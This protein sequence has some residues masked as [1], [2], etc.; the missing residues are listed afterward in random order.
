MSFKAEDIDIDSFLNL[1]S[2]FHSPSLANINKGKG[3]VTPRFQQPPIEKVNTYAPL[4]T[5]QTFAG[6]SHQYNLH[7]QHIPL[8]PG[9]LANS[10]AATQVDFSFNGYSGYGLGSN[11]TFFGE[12]FLDINTMNGSSS[13]Y[14]GSNDMDMDFDTSTDNLYIN[15]NAIGGHEE[16]SPIPAPAEIVR[17]YPG[18]HVQQAALAKQ[19]Q[20][21]QQQQN[22][23]QRRQSL[24]SNQKSQTQSQK[25]SSSKTINKAPVDSAVEE[26]IS[27]LLNQMRQSANA[28]SDNKSEDQSPPPMSRSKKDEEDMDEDE[29]LL[30]SEEGKKLSSKE[31]RQLRN[32]VSARAFRSRRKE[33]IGQLEGEVAQKSTEADTLR[34]E[35]EALKAENTRLTDL[36][37][38]LLSSSAFSSFLND[39]STNGLPASVLAPAAPSSQSVT[40][41]PEPQQSTPQSSM[42]TIMEEEIHFNSLDSNSNWNSGMDFSFA[43]QVF[44]VTNIP[45]SPVVDIAALS[46]K[47]VETSKVFTQEK[48]VAPVIEA[49]PVLEKVEEQ[50]SCDESVEFDESNPAFA[51]FT[52]QASSKPATPAYE[53]F[54]SLSFEKA[55][56][57]FEIVQAS[58]QQDDTIS[59]ATMA[60]FQS[61]SSAL[62]TVSVRIESLILN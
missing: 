9:A 43:P 55:T 47:S 40:P 52:S 61:I 60:R 37:K 56:E 20:Q 15:P 57:R 25:P 28:P 6:P 2:Q 35:N 39:L 27:R 19:Q 48:E 30:A 31:R 33:Y 16:D 13:S 54:G 41:Q 49:A 21:Q 3:I 24:K 17:V 34:A 62:D 42:N 22:E 44:A 18:M 14:G 12:E 32:K 8:P 5:S 1:D 59:A 7:K 11:S 50:Y 10:F 26:R 53:L 51:L 58:E 29:R 45:E 36:T 46:G 4:Q 38:L 23:S